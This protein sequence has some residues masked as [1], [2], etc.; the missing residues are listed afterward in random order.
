MKTNRANGSRQAHT[1]TKPASGTT[2]ESAACTE[3]NSTSTEETWD[4]CIDDAGPAPRFSPLLGKIVD[5]VA[6]QTPKDASPSFWISVALL[7]ELDAFSVEIPVR[8]LA[9]FLNL[10]SIATKNAGLPDVQFAIQQ[11]TSKAKLG[12]VAIHGI[13]IEFDRT[14]VDPLQEVTAAGLPIPTCWFL[15][16]RGFRLVWVFNDAI[17]EAIYDDLARRAGLAMHGADP[18][19]WEPGQFQRLPGCLKTCPDGTVIDV[20]FP[21]HQSNSSALI[22]E[23]TAFPFP[24]RLLRALGDSTCSPGERTHIRD[25]LEQLGIPAPAPGES[26]LYASCPICEL[27]DSRCCY[28]NVAEDGTISAHCVGGHD[29]E[30]EKHWTERQLAVLASVHSGAD[31]VTESFRPLRDLQVTLGS[32]KYIVFR[33]SGWSAVERDAA[34][35]IWTSEMAR[36]EAGDRLPVDQVLGV[37]AVRLL[38]YGGLGPVAVYFDRLRAN[39]AF[40]DS[41][42]QVYIVACEKS[43]SLKTNT[44]EAMSTAAYVLVAKETEE[45]L[46]TLPGW[47]PFALSL[48]NKLRL[49]HRDALRLLGVP[50]LIRDHLPIAHLTENWTITPITNHIQGTL[51]STILDEHE[52]IDAQSFF[53]DLWN[54]GELPLATENDVKLFICLIASPLLRYVAGQLGVYWFVGPPGVG[55]DFLAELARIIWEHVAPNGARVAFD[56]NLAGDLEMKRSFEM[57]AGSVYARA[58][59]ACKRAGMAEMLIRLAGTDTISVRGL[60]QNEKTIPNTFTII[61]DSAEDVP[62]RREISRRTTLIQLKFME[63]SIS[64]GQVHRKIQ[65]AAPGIIKYLK[66]VVESEVP[67]WYLTQANTGSRPLV[68]VALASLFGATLPRVEG[69]DLTE[70]F[71]VMLTF[72]HTPQGKQEG[73]AQLEYAKKRA[74]HESKYGLALPSYRFAMFIDSMRTVPGCHEVID[75]FGNKSRFMVNRIVRESDY[76]DVR[77]GKAPYLPVEL[78]GE[79]YAFRI[80]Q[81]RRFILAPECEALQ[82]SAATSVAVPEPIE[83]A[84]VRDDSAFE[85]D[86]DELLKKAAE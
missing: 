60:Y 73:Q 80:E 43:L 63:D 41:A 3:N 36:R 11:R 17:P 45:G 16:L 19:S 48:L 42:E 70:I 72:T 52:E 4:E 2:R 34:I 77:T 13:I 71:E 40:E 38:G 65:S 78:H 27:H 21:A 25:Y 69:E 49:G 62:D 32:I 18:K 26:V 57:A 84:P 14:S 35:T 75:R 12:L 8:K 68:P 1:D 53:M 79:K 22:A 5:E 30:G 50:E 86:S 23:P 55:K 64:K 56:I 24:Y 44:H 81:S 74:S 54:C 39:L 85:F 28:V 47:L 15:T 67:D 66:R 83:S 58:K 46:V 82:F 51:V 10:L 7:A 59:E 9:E 33:L 29:G 61:A 6:S 76:A 20:D 31:I 37:Y